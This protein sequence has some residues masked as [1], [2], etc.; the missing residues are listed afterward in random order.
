MIK[1]LFSSLL[2][3]CS[4]LGLSQFDEG[5]DAY[6]NKRYKQA[7]IYFLKALEKEKTADLY[8]NVGLTY[9]QEKNYVAA[10][11]YFEHSIKIDPHFEA[12][13]IN[14]GLTQDKIEADAIWSHPY[15]WVERFI[16]S[17]SSKYWII[18]IYTC[19]ILLA[20]ALFL[21]V[22]SKK[23][24]KLYLLI[25]LTTVFVLPLSIY[26]LNELEKHINVKEYCYSKSKTTTLLLSPN[27]LE[28]PDKMEYGKRYA[29]NKQSDNFFQIETEKKRLFWV[30]KKDVYYY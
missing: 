10:L 11:A 1:V 7:Q 21:L 18:T 29:I 2:L 4:F 14:A 22:T 15:K 30:E 23:R 19:S 28:Q 8:Y 5:V 3:F 16:Y 17:V 13:M 25:A 6:K 12:A 20:I 9:F 26:G 27:G 24:R